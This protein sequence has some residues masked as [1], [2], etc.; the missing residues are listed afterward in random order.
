MF[1]VIIALFKRD[2][3]IQK[4]SFRVIMAISIILFAAG[5]LLHF[6]ETGRAAP[7][8]ALLAPLL[9][10]GLYRILRKIFVR[11]FQREP[12]DTYMNW[13]PGLAWDRLFN[14]LYFAGSAWLLL[15]ALIGMRALVKAGW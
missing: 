8:G 2:L 5:W 6:T 3:L 4:E 11:R 10:L 15:S 12:R 9:S 14:M 1:V 13:S 7:S